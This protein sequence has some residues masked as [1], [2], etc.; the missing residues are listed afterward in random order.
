M[1]NQNLLVQEMVD[2]C[3][4]LV[5]RLPDADSRAPI[6]FRHEHLLWMCN[7]LDEHIEIWPESRL[8]RWIG[9][10]QA[11]LLANEMLDLDGLKDMFDKAKVAHGRMGEDLFDHLNPEST[12]ELDIGGQG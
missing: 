2:Q 10:I 3:R 12:F 7:Q 9:F 8:H 5:H 4:Q 11:A 6:P 1:S